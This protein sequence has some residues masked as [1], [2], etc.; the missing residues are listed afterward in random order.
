VSSDGPRVLTSRDEDG[1]WVGMRRACEILGVNQSTLRQWTDTG[2]VPFF[3]TPGGHRRYRES[4][5]RALAAP[6][7]SA[8]TAQLATILLG[9]QDRYQAVIRKAVQTSSWYGQFDDAAR[10]QFRLLGASMLGLLTTYVGGEG[11][12]ERERALHRGRELAAEYGE[13]AAT[14]GLSQVE[15]T[16]AFLLF[17]N[18]VLE[19]VHRW[20]AAQPPGSPRTAEPLRRVTTFMDQV[21]VSMAAAHERS[22]QARQDAAGP[23]A[24]AAP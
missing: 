3:L 22:V 23:P 17:R 14:L 20:L 5:L 7:P 6:G 1:A 10:H 21:L 16:E 8:S 2:R 9:S 13:T 24:P 12:R 19:I 15:A 18:P 11:R 4:D